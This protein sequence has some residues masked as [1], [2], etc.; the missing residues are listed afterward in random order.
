[1]NRLAHEY[2]ISQWIAE[3]SDPATEQ[4][5]QQYFQHLTSRQL[6]VAL[7]AWALL[8]LLFAVPDYQA[9]GAGRNF[10]FLLAYRL[11]IS[12]TLLIIILKIRADTSVFR[13][14]YPIA[15]TAVIQRAD[16]ALYRGKKAGRNRVEVN[17]T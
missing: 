13:I 6:R 17:L 11:G 3:F 5:Y 15:A 1:M 8:L 12:I 16:A 4:A 14:S 10:F 9:L 7:S 2:R